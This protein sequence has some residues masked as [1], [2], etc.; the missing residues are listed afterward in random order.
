MFKILL[1]ILIASFLSAE[2]RSSDQPDLIIRDEISDRKLRS[3]QNKKYKFIHAYR[4]YSPS[5]H[6]YTDFFK[7]GTLIVS[8]K[9][10]HT[11]IENLSIQGCNLKD[12]HLKDINQFTTLTSLSLVG[13][14][15]T[16]ESLNHISSLTR[17][18]NLDLNLN[19]IGDEGIKILSEMSQ[20]TKLNL[21]NNLN[22]TDSGIDFL[23]N[24]TQLKELNILRTNISEDKYEEVKNKWTHLEK[25][26]YFPARKE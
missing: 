18:K 2:I 12:E 15:L 6:S 22:I 21:S 4:V 13:N 8:P 26:N 25:L 20:L 19:Q 10:F 14:R 9:T 24:C 1:T 7:D 16:D 17:L 11:Q 23:K 5:V 3:L